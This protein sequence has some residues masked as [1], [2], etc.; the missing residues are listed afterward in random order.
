MGIYFTLI[1]EFIR[2]KEFIR[3]QENI[4][5]RGETHSTSQHGI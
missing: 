3:T 5:A 1:Y 4:S 2:T